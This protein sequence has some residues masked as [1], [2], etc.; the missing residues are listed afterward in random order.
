[1][2]KENKAAL[3]SSYPPSCSHILI[4]IKGVFL[5][6]D[7]GKWCLN[8]FWQRDEVLPIQMVEEKKCTISIYSSR[9]TLFKNG[10]VNA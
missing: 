2:S 5:L 1:M 4:K 7:L 6:L 3:I 8:G 9:N 10:V